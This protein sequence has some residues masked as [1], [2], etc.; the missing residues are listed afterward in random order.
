MEYLFFYFSIAVVLII[1]IISTYFRP[2]DFRSFVIGIA[3]IAY[4]LVYETVLGG[5]FGLY[6]YLNPR[7]SIIYI[8]LAGV[9]L[10]PAL[11]IIYTLFLPRNG[12]AA[13]G[14]TAVW[15]AAMLI[16]E[17]LSIVSGTIVFTGWRPVPWSVITYLVTYL[18]VYFLY[19][20][21]SSRRVE[22][23]LS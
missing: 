8:V 20:Y 19:K 11:N 7:D 3:T 4:T 1:L 15:I 2:L 5:Y 18:W 9:L 22:F 16:F 14:Y 12:K 13:L 17:Y 6:Y 10:Y 21:L 23:K